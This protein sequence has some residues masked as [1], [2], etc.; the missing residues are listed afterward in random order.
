MN[1]PVI[2][3]R[4]LLSLMIVFL[5]VIPSGCYPSKERVRTVPCTF[6]IREVNKQ[7]YKNSKERKKVLD[8][9]NKKRSARRN[10]N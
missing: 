2:K 10:K 9:V 7:G 8:A 3:L 6:E 4:Y 5:L 1:K